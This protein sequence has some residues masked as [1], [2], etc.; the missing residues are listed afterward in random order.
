MGSLFVYKMAVMISLSEE[1]VKIVN[2]KIRNFIWG[3]KKSKISLDRLQKKKV[4]GGLKLVNLIAKQKTMRISW[5]FK[6]EQD[7]F[8]EAR[9]YNNICQVVKN[10]IWICNLSATD[11]KKYFSQTNMWHLILAAWCELNCR[12]PQMVKEIR[13]QSLWWNSNIRVDGRPFVW[14]SW[15]NKGYMTIDD[16]FNEDGEI[17]INDRSWLEVHQLLTAIPR[18]WKR[19]L[20]NSNCTTGENRLYDKLVNGKNIS[21]QVYNLLIDD[22]MSV[23]K[24]WQ[25]WNADGLIM[26]YVEYVNSFKNLFKR[27]KDP[28]YVD[29]QYLLLLNKIIT[30]ST[31]YDWNLSENQKCTFG[32]PVDE[33]TIHLLCEC[34][35]VTRLF[36]L[37]EE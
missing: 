34:T 5:I 28:K 24:Y 9:M 2:N 31:L 25:R 15:L 36:R 3:G 37:M 22:E 14:A 11:A 26:Q 33:T 18:E 4:Q 1:Q 8:L 29:F 10:K 32:C 23:N 27:V 19:E 20:R 7:P 13:N 30:N 17:V 12:S 6:I 21:Y 16:L 35:Y